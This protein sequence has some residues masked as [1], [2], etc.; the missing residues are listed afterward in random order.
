MANIE[1]LIPHI[2]QWENSITMTKGETLK[3]AYERARA[4]GVTVVKNDSGGPTMCGVTLNT[5]KEWRRKQGKPVPTQA[6]LAKL[7]YAEWLAILKSVF[8]DPCKG[9][10]ITNQAVANM[11]VD[12]RWV[13]GTQAIRDAQTAFSL[14]ADGIV[15]PKTITAL[16]SG[17]HRE[18]FERL[19]YAREAAYRKIVRNRPSQ[20]KFLNGWLNRLNDLKFEKEI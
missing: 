8:W 4:K 19:K 18:T 11:F 15:G 17:S 13:N 6:D 10:Y 7:E 3:H 1:K 20:Q 16:N 2:L 5:F 14:V 9:D 12:W